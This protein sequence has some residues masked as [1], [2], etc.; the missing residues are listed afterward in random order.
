RQSSGKLVLH[1]PTSNQL[2]VYSPLAT[3]LKGQPQIDGVNQI[4]GLQDVQLSPTS[5]HHKG[6]II[7]RQDNFCPMCLRGLNPESN[8]VINPSSSS[9]SSVEVSAVPHTPRSN[10]TLNALEPLPSTRS[11]RRVLPAPSSSSTFL[12][13]SRNVTRDSYF[14]LLSSSRTST[15]L[16]SRAITPPPLISQSDLNFKSRSSSTDSLGPVTIDSDQRTA[17]EGIE[18]P[19][20]DEK[21]VDGYYERFFVEEVR[22]GRGQKGSVFLCTHVLDGNAL[23]HYAVKKIAVGQSSPELVNVLREVKW[24]ESLRHRNITQYHHA[25]IEKA[26]L[27]RFGP[28]VPVLYILM[29]YANGGS[30]DH[31]ISLR[32][33]SQSS[34]RRS[35]SFPRSGPEI[36]EDLERRRFKKNLFRQ[37]RKLNN[38]VLTDDRSCL[39]LKST[40]ESSSSS[41]LTPLP[42]SIPHDPSY[43]MAIHLFGLEEIL[44]VFEDTCRGLG[45]LHSKGILHHDLK[46][47]NVLLHWESEDSMIPTA[48]ISDFGS[49]VAQSENWRR[50]RTGRTG[51]LDWVPPESLKKDPRTGKLFEVTQKG[52]MWQLGL[53]LHFLCF[54]RL[55]YTES[56]DIKKLEDEIKSYPGYLKPQP[57]FLDKIALSFYQISAG[58]DF[59]TETQL[60]RSDLPH[61]LLQLLSS[62]LSL[63]PSHRPSC[64][65]VL[66]TISNI[67]ENDRTPWRGTSLL[68]SQIGSISSISSAKNGTRRRTFG[69]ARKSALDDGSDDSLQSALVKR[70]RILDSAPE[71]SEPKS[72]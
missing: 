68:G 12:P 34:R 51:T 54:F 15:P 24:L 29:D 47:E 43:E 18:E 61:S 13:S 55:P 10:I 22:L 46:S 20:G 52:D 7:Q 25:W 21:R 14:N 9:P 4:T 35:S 59:N 62:L 8:P 16:P 32:K 11:Y 19:L 37:R 40:Q 36:D 26:Q 42:T 48:L 67:R 45:F 3:Q 30:L 27:T 49:S 50:E 31:Y 56:D 58:W 64:E 65:S 63:E 17:P 6:L 71:N 1:N 60:S 53:V 66:E 2:I 57:V 39:D 5:S 70:K 23:G 72:L 33:G 41:T 38:S 28:R 44:N 69:V